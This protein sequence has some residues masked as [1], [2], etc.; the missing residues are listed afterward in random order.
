MNTFFPW[1][2]PRTLEDYYSGPCLFMALYRLYQGAYY[3]KR[4]SLIGEPFQIKDFRE[5]IDQLPLDVKRQIFSKI[6]DEGKPFKSVTIKRGKLLLDYSLYYLFI[7]YGKLRSIC[8]SEV[9]R[10]YAGWKGVRVEKKVYKFTYGPLNPVIP[11]IIPDFL[12]LENGKL[13]SISFEL[14]CP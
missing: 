14:I 5:Q 8:N 4:Y 10:I 6:W 7:Q 13:P 3:G 9:P 12:C 2:V 11:P 1:E